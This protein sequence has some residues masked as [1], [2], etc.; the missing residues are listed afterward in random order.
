[1]FQRIVLPLSLPVSA[2]IVFL[3]FVTSWTNFFL[4][5]VMCRPFDEVS[6][7]PV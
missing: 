6:R 3:N 4:P 5:S 1:L 7:Y 2:W